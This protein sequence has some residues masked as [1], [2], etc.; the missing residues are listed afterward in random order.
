VIILRIFS[1]LV[2]RISIL[3]LI[4]L[5]KIYGDPQFLQR[6]LRG[7]DHIPPPTLKAYTDC[8]Q[9]I[10]QISECL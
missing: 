8:G 7:F 6:K 2:I 9:R 4:T 5:H 3:V 1:G 10:A